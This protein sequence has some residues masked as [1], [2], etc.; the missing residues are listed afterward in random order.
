MNAEATCTGNVA[1]E[2]RVTIS[3]IADTEPMKTPRFLSN[4]LGMWIP[5]ALL[6]LPV[7]AARTLIVAS[8]EPGEP[9]MPNDGPTRF[10]ISDDGS[11]T[12]SVPQ[13]GLLAPDAID[14]AA[15]H[16]DTVPPVPFAQQAT[17]QE[18]RPAFQEGWI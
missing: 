10:V 11:E 2:P 12:E 8:E 7:L 16:F 18:A 9:R 14:D 6:V 13:P 3:T 17:I 15:A 5:L 1:G 4:R